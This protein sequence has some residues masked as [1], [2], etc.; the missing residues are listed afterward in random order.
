MQVL[1]YTIEPLFGWRPEGDDLVLVLPPRPGHEVAFESGSVLTASTGFLLMFGFLAWFIGG[2]MPQDMPALRVLLVVV[3]LMAIG[4]WVLVVLRVGW[5]LRRTPV[6][7]RIRVGRAGLTVIDALPPGPGDGHWGLDEIE[8]VRMDV[9]RGMLGTV[10]RLRLQIAVCG[11]TVTSYMFA[12]PPGVPSQLV[13]ARLREAL[14]A[15]RSP[16]DPP[17]LPDSA[18][19]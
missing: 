11:G 9:V 15:C 16:G 4:Q 12:W 14:A 13:E 5:Q 10:R 8:R 18:N 6:E 3:G 1:D 17:P 19:R 2:Q 7:G